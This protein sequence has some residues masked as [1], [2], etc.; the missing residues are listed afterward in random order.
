M[1]KFL[2][3]YKEPQSIETEQELLGSILVFGESVFMFAELSGI[4]TDH[5]SYN[6]HKLIWRAMSLAI[7]AGRPVDVLQITEILANQ[8]WLDEIGGGKEYL[9]KLAEAAIAPDRVSSLIATLW[10]YHYARQVLERCMEILHSYSL[11]GDW[12][13]AI[14]NLL[15]TLIS[16]SSPFEAPTALSAPEVLALEK[17]MSFIIEPFLPENG[18]LLLAGSAAVGKSLLALW[19]AICIA[20]GEPI[21]GQFPTTASTTL[22]LDGEASVEG[23]KR[24]LSLLSPQPPSNLYYSQWSGDLLSPAG[25]AQMEYL[26]NLY[27]PS[28]VVL[29]S[30]IRFHNLN[31]ND[32]AAM[33]AFYNALN[34][35]RI[36]HNT[37]F[38]VIQHA[39][40]STMFGSTMDAIR[41]S[42]EIVA[43]SD[44]A[45]FLRRP[46]KSN[47]ITVDILKLRH[48]E[49]DYTKFRIS[50]NRTVT[51]WTYEWLGVSEEVETSV[52]EAAKTI[53]DMLEGGELSRQE[54]LERGK[55]QGLSRAALDRALKQLKTDGSIIAVQRGRFTYYHLAEQSPQSPLL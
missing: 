23:H 38:I 1:K 24:R 47:T 34:W 21:F 26:L 40:K 2:L 31:E 20:R 6:P 11:N 32:P 49:L 18:I 7:K 4:T 3:D 16:P 28:T 14:Q 35:F 19:F 39:R 22:Y 48:S 42:T 44:T 53:K 50:L 43:F 55:K 51:P 30:M 27:Q 33:K 54:I 41:G 25:K 36:R 13:N 45:L 9:V 10:E 37:A 17:H 5:F 15:L 8:G 12:K 29:D 46:Q 52:E